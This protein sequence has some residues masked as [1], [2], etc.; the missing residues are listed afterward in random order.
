MTDPIES[1]RQSGVAEHGGPEQ[2]PSRSVGAP[3]TRRPRAGMNI[4]SRLIAYCAECEMQ[5]EPHG[6]KP[7]GMKPHGMHHTACTTRHE[8]TRHAAH[9][10]E[11]AGEAR[12]NK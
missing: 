9:G 6:M 7:H 12:G 1:K 3:R 8:T 2:K 4:L 11:H 5:H 10:M